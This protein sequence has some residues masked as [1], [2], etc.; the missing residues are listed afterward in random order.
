MAK[1]KANITLNNTS[2]MGA[3]RLSHLA[4]ET[5]QKVLALRQ[6]ICESAKPNT[7]S[8]AQRAADLAERL[9]RERVESHIRPPLPILFKPHHEMFA[10]ADGDK[11]DIEDVPFELR[12]LNEAKKVPKE[13]A[14]VHIS[15][16]ENMLD[17]AEQTSDKEAEAEAYFG[18]TQCHLEKGSFDKML[19]CARKFLTLSV[20]LHRLKD[21][22][23]AHEN[24]GHACYFKSEWGQ[25]RDS[26]ERSFDCA[27]D[28]KHSIGEGTPEEQAELQAVA[29]TGMGN[30]Y[31]RMGLL[32]DAL[33]SYRRSLGANLAAGNRAGVKLAEANVSRTE[34]A[35]RPHL[36][37]SKQGIVPLLINTKDA[38]QLQRVGNHKA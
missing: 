22:A 15:I 36:V 10:Y 23:I 16:Y 35:L 8:I 19:A 1:V 14:G 34:A 33:R 29:L 9:R 4:Q 25:A 28:C 21:Q 17:A 37:F 13:T 26:Y 12:L 7:K 5:A 2:R 11:D 31:F 3:E 18:M 32:Q 30:A 6:D 20:H 24:I 27:R 38:N